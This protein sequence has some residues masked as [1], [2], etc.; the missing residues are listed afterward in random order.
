MAKPSAAS[1][2][3]AEGVY[4]QGHRDIKS[5]SKLPQAFRIVRTNQH[6]HASSNQSSKQGMIKHSQQVLNKQIKH[7]LRRQTEARANPADL[8]GAGPLPV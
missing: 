3:Q 7:A 2:E 6:R 5:S 4:I 1:R 8:Q